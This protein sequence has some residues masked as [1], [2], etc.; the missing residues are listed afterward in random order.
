L[1]SKGSKK[2]LNFESGRNFMKSKMMACVIVALIMGFGV[3]AW[4]GHGYKGECPMMDGPH[5]G[6][7]FGPM[8]MLKGLDL[9]S[10]QQA[11]VDSLMEQ[12][13]GEIRSMDDKVEAS[14][15]ALHEAIHS[16]VFDEQKIREASKSLAVNKEEMDVL[17]GRIF[18][19]IRTVLT[20]EQAAQLKEMKKMHQERMKCHEKCGKMMEE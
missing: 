5:H 10:E 3:P 9:T 13:K 2:F 4:A 15:K 6:K 19:E 8:G 20:P 11:K 12:H 16:D 18:A 17:R 7:G 14:R 1:I